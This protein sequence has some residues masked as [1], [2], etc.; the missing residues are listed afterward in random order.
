VSQDSLAGF[1]LS[2][3]QRSAWSRWQD[4][5]AGSTWCALLLE[6]PLDPSRLRQ[7]AEAVMGS[8]EILRTN[9]HRSPG[10]RAPLQVVRERG[11]LGW[12]ES[13][14]KSVDAA[15]PIA[16]A[17]DEIVREESASPWNL[18]AG[19]ALRLRLREVTNSS[20]VLLITLPALSGDRRTLHEIA[21]ALAE[22]YARG[23]RPV[24][25][26]ATEEPI[27]YAD[28]AQWQEDLAAAGEA[29][30]NGR[31]YWKKM[32]LP[33]APKLPFETAAPDAPRSS[34]SEFALDPET[35][36]KI[37]A[38]A[39]SSGTTTADFLMACWQ[40]LLL[41][42]TGEAELAI[43][44]VH[45]GRSLD[46]LRHALGRFALSLPVAVHAA[47]ERPF[48]E[49]VRRASEARKK[50]EE[51]EDYFVRD[52]DA[53]RSSQSPESSASV[54]F[55]FFERPAL[56]EGAGVSF[57]ILADFA[58]ADAFSA[59]VE[60]WRDG[61]SIR[62]ACGV[63]PRK[64][65]AGGAGRLA[66]F[67]QVLIAAAAETPQSPSDAL[68]I[69]T[70]AQRRSRI[71]AAH[72]PKRDF[73]RRGIHELFEEQVERSPDRPALVFA[74]QRLTYREL[75]TRS[76]A[77]A[78]RLR[79]R[80]VGLD[81][82][83]GLCVERSADMIVGLLA[84]LKAGG[85]Y[86][87][88]VPD[89][90]GARLCSELDR[91]RARL[92]LTH[93]QSADKF[94]AFEG[95]TILL[96]APSEPTAEGKAGKADSPPPASGV[97]GLAYV[98]YTSGSTGV[99]K[100]VAVRHESLVNYATFI[101]RELL[102]ID[103][104]AERP[105]TFATVS[106][107][108]ADLGNTAIFPSLISGGC[109][110]V[111]P[112]ET[113]MEGTLFAEYLERDPIDVLKIV[114][115]HMAAIL[116][117]RNGRDV[118][119]RKFLILGGEALSWD[120][121]DRI[122]ALGGTCEIVNHYGPTETT[123]GSLT[124]RVPPET[125]E[126]PGRSVP[127]GSPIAN[128]EA[129]VLDARLQPVP[130]E[131]PG[132]LFIGGAGLAAGYV[133]EPAETAERFVPDPFSGTP[134][135][136]LY[137]TGDRVRSL[138]D[139]DV[140]FLGRVDDQVKIRG[141]RI[142]PGEIRGVL[143]AHPAVRECIVLARED[144]PGDLR[145]VAYVVSAAAVQVSADELRAWMRTQVP[146]YMVPAAFVFL[147]SLPLTANGK[148]DR[149]AL[150]PPREGAEE[151]PYIAPRSDSE[152]KVAETWREVL[153]VERVGA[154]DNFF[155]LGGHSLLLTQVVSRLR[156]VFKRDLPIR[157][158]FEVPTVAGLAARI[159]SA[160]REELARILDEVESLPDEGSERREEVR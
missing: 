72:G 155:D 29:A 63:D 71:D 132:E 130:A 4:S 68:P 99:P 52:E 136:R 77:L 5:A 73:P 70:A 16:G 149:R 18:E 44:Q 120:L 138:R 143:E 107:I 50:N 108:A 134:G 105:M 8:H 17:V 109:L 64:T 56:P 12:E 35:A 41:R 106:T 154:D 60:A 83:V 91:S 1:R 45:E 121:V 19:P 10:M 157:W 66:G 103:P 25:G 79:E 145:L 141:F 104:H 2:A 59:F 129:F 58:P 36:E 127:I 13:P 156:K 94:S 110:H 49:T 46:D 150:P 117:S 40:T 74:G 7:A 22:G 90:P 14:P 152:K 9:Y 78:W 139:G 31:A 88:L 33:P 37:E 67:L 86:L 53:D 51:W 115:S 39:S 61:S 93:S 96:D 81:S 98:L 131:T 42:I 118:L 20:H 158:L 69:L 26:H 85:A 135:A 80:G 15:G 101:A 28:Y 113:A 159:D 151:R 100:G 23:G 142:E 89:Q 6:G 82:P 65:S 87:P 160:E 123:V 48:A 43:A 54:G 133:S 112:Y 128:T 62:I 102:G 111:I 38:F 27:Q 32:A 144:S 114:P 146:D 137:R 148:V 119:P 124:Y 11:S 95:E 55:D 122:R 3:Q 76:N 140:E 116:A 126:R 24:D 84:I 125:A 21:R 30:E 92:V 153:R 57:T 47:G 75:N 97:P 147:K 34:R